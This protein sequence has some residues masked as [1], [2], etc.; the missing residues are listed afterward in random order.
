MIDYA[1]WEVILNGDSPP[2]TRSVD[3]VKITY[4]P[5]T[6]EEKL[7]RKNDLKARG[8][9]LMALPNEHQLKFNSYKSSKSLMEAIEKRFGGNKESKKSNSSQLDNEDLKQINPDD[10]EEIDLKLQMEILTMKAKRFLQKTGR[11]LGVKG[12]KTIGFDKTEVECYNCHKRCHFTK[13]CRAPK[14][15]DNINREEPRK[16]VP[17]EVVFE[18]DIKILKLDVMF[19]DKVITELRQKFKKAEKERDALKLTLEKFE[20]S[21]KNL[22]ILL[23]NQQSDKSKIGLGYDSQGFDSQVLENQ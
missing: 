8:T 2:P 11:N 18:E 15:Q 3:G 14:H 6:T 22:S 1:L 10:L 19:R 7:A 13:E 9:L 23:D 17:N 12:T 5:T 21:S 4:P 16:T 20:G